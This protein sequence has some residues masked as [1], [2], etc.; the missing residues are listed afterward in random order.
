MIGG[1][2]E[3]TLYHYCLMKKLTIALIA[4]LSL[5]A[6][7]SPAQAKS[8]TKIGSMSGTQA[9]P[10]ICKT[11]KGKRIWVTQVAAPV[12]RTPGVLSIPIFA[13]Y[14]GATSG[15][16]LTWGSPSDVGSSA[17]TNYRLEVMTEK[18]PWTFVINTPANSWLQYVTDVNLS[19]IN[20]RFR[21][22][23][24][25]TQ[26]VGVFSESD[27]VL[28]GF[29]TPV[30]V[31][32]I[33]TTTTTT[34]AQTTTTTAYVTNSRTQAVKKAADYLR[35]TSFSRSGLISQ[36]EYSKFST[37]DATYAVDA[38]NVDWNSQAAKKAASYLKISSF[39]RQG[40][41]EQLVYEG[42]SQSQAE[43]GVNAVGL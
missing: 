14:M 18:M 43:Y 25:N 13:K 8:C 23:A 28:Y 31:P 4:A 36:L 39:S 34:V 15:I 5:F 11:V 35:V 42:F 12:T 2:S 24:Q 27:W 6:I 17:V 33:S 41:I 1:F 37:E 32:T 38:Q 40:L 26:G 10:L 19:M 7:G 3:I 30:T 29:T 9:K 16:L 21:I 20:F 22:A